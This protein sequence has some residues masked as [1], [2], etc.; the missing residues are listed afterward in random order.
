M[1]A[2]QGLRAALSAIVLCAS[3]PVGAWGAVKILDER[4]GL[5]PTVIS[6]PVTDTPVG[7][8]YCTEDLGIPAHNALLDAASL[9]SSVAPELSSI[10]KAE[11]VFA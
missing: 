5:S 4:F 10:A 11:G 3:D 2:D 1:L 7:R 8:R 6:G 9:A